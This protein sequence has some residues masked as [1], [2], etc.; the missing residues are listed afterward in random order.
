MSAQIRCFW[1]HEAWPEAW[2][3][4]GW[5]HKYFEEAM[6]QGG[7]CQLFQEPMANMLWILA[8]LIVFGSE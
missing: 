8:C 7:L 5:S 4:Q 1:D 3:E 2:P 6:A